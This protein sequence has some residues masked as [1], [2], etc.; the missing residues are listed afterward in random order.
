[1]IQSSSGIN[2]INTWNTLLNYKASMVFHMDHVN[3]TGISTKM[4]PYE[5]IDKFKESTQYDHA[6]PYKKTCNIC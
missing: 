1:M 5:E 6:M 2:Y 3:G 4:S